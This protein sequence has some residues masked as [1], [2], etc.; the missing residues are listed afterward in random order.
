MPDS[1]SWKF[2]DPHRSEFLSDS[3]RASVPAPV[4]V[5]HQE[6]PVVELRD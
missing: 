6:N 5:R 4:S 1:Q 2:P 3:D